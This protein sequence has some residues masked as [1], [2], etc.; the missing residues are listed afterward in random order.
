MQ[1]VVPGGVTISDIHGLRPRPES[2]AR[3]NEEVE[4]AVVQPSPGD[5]RLAVLWP[6]NTPLPARF[7]G[8]TSSQ[9]NQ[10]L[11]VGPRS[12][13]NIQALRE[14]LPWLRPQVLGLQTSAGFGDRLGLAR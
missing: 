5:E 1:R 7:E 10:L 11:L 4:V 8:E 2:V 13:A 12:A 9:G 6:S 3:V 14:C